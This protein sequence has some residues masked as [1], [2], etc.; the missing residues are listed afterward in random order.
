VYRKKA[1][2]LILLAFVNRAVG[3]AT[4]IVIAR[5][6]GPGPVTDAF[7]FTSFF[8]Q[9]AYGITSGALSMPFLPQLVRS[10]RARR[11]SLTRVSLIVIG[12]CATLISLFLILVPQISLGS[13]G[14]LP[15]IR[16]LSFP[17][18]L[19]LITIVP[20]ALGGFLYMMLNAQGRHRL[21]IIVGLVISLLLFVSGAAASFYR[22]ASYLFYGTF[23]AY[24]I[25]LVI[26]WILV[27]R[28]EH[29]PL[30]NFDPPVR[31]TQTASTPRFSLVVAFC[32][33]ETTGF[34]INQ[35]LNYHFAA[36][37]GTGS[38]TLYALAYR[39]TFV[40]LPILV[41]PLSNMMAVQVAQ[42]PE[43]AGARRIVVKWFGVAVG[44]AAAYFV[45][46]VVF[47]APL[48]NIAFRGQSFHAADAVRLAALFSPTGAWFVV[49]AANAIIARWYYD[50]NKGAFYVSAC[51]AAYATST[52]LKFLLFPYVGL[53]GV[54]WLCVATEG[55][56]CCTLVLLEVRSAWREKSIAA[57][58]Q[59]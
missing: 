47:G 37:T 38:V 41:T 2:S 43:A 21:P 52:I 32:L 42:H 58:K 39:F 54:V 12:A 53:E 15:E 56:A 44:L 34:L 7:F 46:L 8:P 4:Q 48:V 11:R 16:A 26:S 50:Q 5:I 36:L 20:A 59:N 28:H 23:V 25:G 10:E 24:F 30:N 57:V 22:V 14:N 17:V 33:I 29:D 3:F 51:L 1:F 40:G 18:S 9:Y 35:T 55:T 6:F 45:L 49:I 13:V 27:K 31:S 19:C